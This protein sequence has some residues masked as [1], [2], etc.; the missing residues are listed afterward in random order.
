[1]TWLTE[2]LQSC[3][4]HKLLNKQFRVQDSNVR[5]STDQSVGRVGQGMVD[6]ESGQSQFGPGQNRSYYVVHHFPE[7]ES[8]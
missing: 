3:D 6:I 7:K 8:L 1:V 5:R 2:V 4:Q